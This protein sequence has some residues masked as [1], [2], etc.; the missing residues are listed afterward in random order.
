MRTSTSHARTLVSN[1]LFDNVG[2]EEAVARIVRMTQKTDRPRYVCTGNLDHLVLLQ[3]DAE[4]RGI[5]AEADLV[6]ADGAPVVWLS[7]LPGGQPLQERVTGSDLFWELARASASTG[8]RLFFL[9]GQPGAADRAADAVRRRHPSAQ[10]CGT[11]CP[12][13][14]AFDTPAEQARIRAV[15]AEAQ[16]DILLVGLG[17]PKQEKWIHAHKEE[18]GV[19]VLIGVGGTFEMAGGVVKRAPLW[20]QRT[21]CEWAYRLCQEPRRLWR[22]YL[23]NDLPFLA[24]LLFQT[25]TRPRPSERPAPAL[26]LIHESVSTRPVLDWPNPGSTAGEKRTGNGRR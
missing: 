19:P 23:V 8:V 15:I 3:K 12:D 17:A 10:V 13:F 4:F 14:A 20:M 6:L 26:T 7:R 25:L 22:R 2:M 16:P 9:G 1:V 11:D 18:I 5:Y 24:T 21:G